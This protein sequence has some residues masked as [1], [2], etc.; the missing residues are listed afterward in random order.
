MS[1]FDAY[2]KG[3]FGE[4]E[5]KTKDYLSFDDFDT[6]FSKQFE[7]P[8]PELEDL[9]QIDNKITKLPFDTMEEYKQSIEPLQTVNMPQY[10]ENRQVLEVNPIESIKKT[11]KPKSKLDELE[12]ITDKR[13]PISE[14]PGFNIEPTKIVQEQAILPQ[15]MI[16]SPERAGES[17]QDYARELREGAMPIE[18]KVKSFAGGA[19][20]TVTGIK[21]FTEVLGAKYPEKVNQAIATIQQKLAVENP[22][23]ADKLFSGG[24]SMATFFIPGLG[25]AK[26]GTLLANAPKLANASGVAISAILESAVNSGS[27]YEQLIAS[28]YSEKEAKKKAMLSFAMNLP[29][30]VL[31]SI[32]PDAGQAGKIAKEIAKGSLKEGS[33]EY[34]QTVISNYVTDKPLTEGATE[35]GVIGGILG[36]GVQGVRSALSPKKP[37]VIPPEQEILGL[38]GRQAPAGLLPEAQQEQI[39]IPPT[40]LYP[41]FP[42]SKEAGIQGPDAYFDRTLEGANPNTPRLERFNDIEQINIP[43]TGPTGMGPIELPSSPIRTMLLP[44][45][46][47]SRIIL[48]EA[49][50]VQADMRRALAKADNKEVR[51]LNNELEKLAD[52]YDKLIVK[53]EPKAP[54]IQ[55]NLDF[56]EEIGGVESMT[57]MEQEVKPNEKETKEYLQ[58]SK[59]IKDKAFH[60]TNTKGITSLDISKTGTATD[61]GNVGTAIVLTPHKLVALG[62]KKNASGELLNVDY[63]LKNPLE[64]IRDDNYIN[65]IKNLA[66]ELGVVSESKWSGTKQQ[67]K[68]FADEFRKKALDKGYDGYIERWNN[69]AKEIIN[70]GI[71]NPEKLKINRENTKSTDKLMVEDI[72]KQEPTYRVTTTEVIPIRQGIKGVRTDDKTYTMDGK[73]VNVDKP[74]VKKQVDKNIPEEIT[75]LGPKMVENFTKAVTSKEGAKDILYPDNKISRKAWT[76]Y[77]GVDLPKTIRDTQLV[78]DD[79]FDNGTESANKLAKTFMGGNKIVGYINKRNPDGS[80]SFKQ[81]TGELIELDPKLELMVNKSN[82]VYVVTDLK[83]GFALNSGSRDKAT[84]IQQAKDIINA[85]GVDEVIRVRDK[86]IQ[87]FGESPYVKEKGLKSEKVGI[88]DNRGI[89]DKGG[90]ENVQ[91]TMREGSEGTSTTARDREVSKPKE[92]LQRTASDTD[93]SGLSS[94]EFGYGSQRSVE[95]RRGSFERIDSIS[96]EAVQAYSSSQQSL[97]DSEVKEAILSVED[98][99][100]YEQK[101]G[102]KDATG[103]EILS[104]YFTPTELSTV[105]QNLLK[106]LTTGKKILEPSIGSGNLIEQLKG[107]KVTGIELN[108]RAANVT[109]SKFPDATIYN[110][111]SEKFFHDNTEKFD[112]VIM[113]PPYNNYISYFKTKYGDNKANTYTEYFLKES[114]KVLKPNGVIVA[115]FPH[116]FM[117]GPQKATKNIMNQ[118]GMQVL[119]A[120]RLPDGI[121]KTVKIPIDLV[122]FQK[123]GM[124]TETAWNDNN[125]FKSNPEDVLGEIATSKGNYGREIEIVKGDLPKAYEK[126]N[127]YIKTLQGV[128]QVEEIEQVAKKQ[129]AVLE[130]KPKGKAIKEVT[131]IKTDTSQYGE[132]VNE[133]IYGNL[134]YDGSTNLKVSEN[135]DLLNYEDGKVFPNEL[136]VFG[137]IPEKLAQ[138]E[139][140]KSKISAEQYDKQK[141]LLESV[142]PKPLK[143]KEMELDPS[144]M[145]FKDSELVREYRSWI[146]RNRKYKYGLGPSDIDDYFKGRLSGTAGQRKEYS[147]DESFAKAVDTEMKKRENRKKFV[148]E[149]FKDY[150]ME[151]EQNDPE[152]LT[153]INNDLFS[154]NVPKFDKFP[155]FIKDLSKT[156]KGKKLEISQHQKE[157]IGFLSSR[158]IGYFAGE[159]GA[160][161]TMVNIVMVEKSLQN[162]RS[163]RPVI[164]APK[165]ILQNFLNE[166]PELF[167]KRKLVNLENLGATVKLPKLEDGTVYMM[168]YEALANIK[169]KEAT[170]NKV[171]GF[172]TEQ[173]STELGDKDKRL[174]EIESLKLESLIAKISDKGYFFEDLGFDLVSFDEAHEMRNLFSFKSAE[175]KKMPQTVPSQVAVRGYVF[176]A[177]IFLNNNYQNVFLYSATPFNNKPDEIYNVLSFVAFGKMKDMGVSNLEDF[178]KL[179]AGTNYDWT[180]GPN[181]DLRRQQVVTGFNN[182]TMLRQL[183]RSYVL[184]KFSDELDLVR[185][186]KKRVMQYLEES[187]K[188]REII[189]PLREKYS[190]LNQ[191]SKDEQK[192]ERLSLQTAIRK[193]AVSPYLLEDNISQFTAKEV[194]E[195]SSKLKY[196]SDQIKNLYDQNN[197]SC[198]LIYHP[199]GKEVIPKWMEYLVKYKKFKPEQVAFISGETSKNLRE[200]IQ[201]DYNSG[202]IKILIGTSAIKQGLNLQSKTVAMYS[203]LI[204]WNPTDII[205]FE[206]RAFRQGNQ[207][208]GVWSVYPLLENSGDA[209]Y[210][211]K[212]EEKSKRF[213][214]LWDGKSNYIDTADVN[215]EQAKLDIITDPV[216][217]AEA[218]IAMDQEKIDDLLSEIKQSLTDINSM[219]TSKVDL[220]DDWWAGKLN[221]EHINKLAEKEVLST[222]EYQGLIDDT[223]QALHDIYKEKLDNKFNDRV[224]YFEE[225]YK[226]KH[227]GKTANMD[228]FLKKHPNV[229]EWDYPTYPKQKDV[230]LQRTYAAD[231]IIG[232]NGMSEDLIKRLDEAVKKKNLAVD[233]L[234]TILEE[235][236]KTKQQEKEQ[237]METKDGL[238]SKFSREAQKPKPPIEMLKTFEYREKTSISDVVSKTAKN[239]DKVIDDILGKREGFV[240]FKEIS[241]KVKIPDEMKFSEEVEARW[242]DAKGL[243]QP[244]FL[245]KAS[246]I[247]MD[248]KGS[249]RQFPLLDP[250]S[251]A[252]NVDLLREF[253]NN[254]EY[255]KLLAKESIKGILAKLDATEYELFTRGLILPDIKKDVDRGLYENKELPFGIESADDLELYISNTN[256]IIEAN[257]NV[258]EAIKLRNDLIGSIQQELIEY[259]L[260][261]ESVLEYDAYFHHQVLEYMAIKKPYTGT[262]SKDVRTHK[263]GFQKG[264]MGSSKDFNTEYMEAEFEMLAQALAQINTQKILNKLKAQ[265]DITELVENDEIPEGYVKWQPKKG[266]NFYLA[267]S[268][269]DKVINDIMSG[270]TKFEEAE[271]RQVLAMGRKKSEWIIPENLAKTLDDLVPEQRESIL[272]AISSRTLSAWKSYILIN[273]IRF[274]KYNINNMSGDLDIVFAYNPVILK[275]MPKAIVD[276]WSYHGQKKGVTKEFTEMVRLGVISSGL[277]LKEIPD[278]KTQ[279]ILVALNGSNPNPIAKYWDTVGNFTNYRENILRVAAYRYFLENTTDKYGASNHVEIDN[280]IASGATNQQLAAK[281]ARELIGDY[282]KTSQAGTWIARHMFPFFRWV[283]VNSPRYYNLLKNLPYEGRGS[284]GTKTRIALTTAVKVPGLYIKASII[285]ALIV[286]W[287]RTMFPDEDRTINRERNQLQLILGVRKDGSIIS[288]RFQGAFSDVLAWVGLDDYPYLIADVASGKKSLM[289]VGKSMVKAPINK[290]ILGSRPFEK[291]AFEIMSGKRLY[292]DI[293]KPVPIRDK[294]EHL[295][296]LFSLDK[297]YKRIAGLPTR[298]IDADVLDLILYSTDPGESSYYAIRELGYK[299]LEEQ[300]KEKP[301]GEPTKRSN[302]LYYYKQAKKLGDEAKSEKFKQLYKSEGGTLKGMKQSIKASHPLGMIKQNERF[303]FRNTLSP[304]ELEIYDRALKWYKETYTI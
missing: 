139:E 20:G 286:L 202:K 62:Y 14:K 224:Q 216:K 97:A 193:A 260:L 285:F 123:T 7:K 148:K 41:G 11:I 212:V 120:F 46:D 125:Y 31:T 160:G 158:N 8:Q 191:L 144:V 61:Q 128:E 165:D 104:A 287:N 100:T 263:K 79:Y 59:P 143:A 164:I 266:N 55:K 273:P 137:N 105:M 219:K 249:L 245:D 102:K 228:T 127:E 174:K 176:S 257:P 94:R 170:I 132:A 27:D 214:D 195:N 182:A 111:W 235:R 217:K 301:A 65:N 274:I 119:K 112:A 71:Y 222:K 169:Y 146:Y 276:L 154:T 45:A 221:V 197:D 248:L 16:S 118:E 30:N 66:K 12:S 83:S 82:G 3:F 192:K 23:F 300:G 33:Q 250:K 130:D 279:D 25:V 126:I 85:K 75:K 78:I 121:F 288:L 291:T 264:R 238:I 275:N 32:I 283:E 4:E 201:K 242:Q 129:E 115:I 134:N 57:P 140:D 29:L 92:E 107:Y 207:F 18:N 28:G 49:K 296:K 103:V 210:L 17:Q 203:T 150:L 87:S 133:A 237:L 188:E 145:Y 68:E 110:T 168:S 159:V 114:S 225:K 162:G 268:L 294:K 34:L 262:S 171:L 246:D 72:N 239:A 48:E 297:V 289:D 109:K 270:A 98:A 161:K 208:V 40:E 147:T 220:G 101:G 211:Q 136:Y 243:R 269:T 173:T 200:Q 303:K 230:Y 241:S 204:E 58:V 272:G 251:D 151:V 183:I 302:Y 172:L 141:K 117:S 155:F 113:N 91:G 167:P 99:L 88:V 265:N 131:G 56:V 271:F 277:T 196:I 240:G 9:S 267:D 186:D 278:I 149:T 180:V 80:G 86:T 69:K 206:G 36:G 64:I 70:I 282:G 292:P 261:P 304:D 247:G 42:M 234:K 47:K 108:K 198:Q 293:F 177:N 252:M 22:T 39:N 194:V 254:S 10:N 253:K 135:M 52:D 187:D 53:E 74:T 281:L 258:K 157:A 227:P 205:Q 138:L 199:L 38:E 76:E 244:T 190:K 54:D 256:K 116:S 280:L 142:R 77:T 15:P 299:Y 43:G 21:G 229:P 26:L 122:V 236:E 5:E 44:E 178:T 223:R 215:P 67:S 50:R 95:P 106:N 51:R 233:E 35:A 213:N 2:S 60:Y 1:R 209:V 189:G 175:F 290:F 37:E 81:V 284:A 63:D 166:Y 73:E 184:P 90:D 226:V 232:I 93:D 218:S 152:A 255:S 124:K 6:Q 181:N 163:K 84:S 24:G 259:G 156:F 96:D 19:F 185:P 153:K 231:T 298:K 89:I 179:F 295:A 13:T